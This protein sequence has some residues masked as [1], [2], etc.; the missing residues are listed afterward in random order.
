MFFVL[1]TLLP[2][3][4]FKQHPAAALV[5]SHVSVAVCALGSSVGVSAEAACADSCVCPCA[6]VWIW[7]QQVSDVQG[8]GS[9]LPLV[10][11]G[12]AH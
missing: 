7:M 2:V 8:G 10:S 3:A 6:C 5:D 11:L 1:L 12:E 9:V 4:P